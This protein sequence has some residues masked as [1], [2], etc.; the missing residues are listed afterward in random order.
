M[1][2]LSDA[3]LSTSADAYLGFRPAGQHFDTCGHQV[4]FSASFVP[5]AD[6]Y[7]R[8][9]MRRHRRWSN[10]FHSKKLSSCHGRAGFGCSPVISAK[11]YLILCRHANRFQKGRRA[12]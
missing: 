6:D 8:G 4:A 5:H 9:V 7:L 11:Y 12:E 3:V 1:L 10:H 2:L